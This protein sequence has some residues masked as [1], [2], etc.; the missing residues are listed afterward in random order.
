MHEA[1][2]VLERQSLNKNILKK[3]KNIC[4]KEIYLASKSYIFIFYY[5][6][7]RQKYCTLYFPQLS[8]NLV[9]GYFTVTDVKNK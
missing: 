2:P 5:A 4:V 6:T 8:D 1:K 3:N 7:F 9:S